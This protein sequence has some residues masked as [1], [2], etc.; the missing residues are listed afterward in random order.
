MEPPF[1]PPVEPTEPPVEPTEP[2][3]EPIPEKPLD[4]NEGDED[5]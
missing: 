5:E 4:D 2:P 3:T 1:E